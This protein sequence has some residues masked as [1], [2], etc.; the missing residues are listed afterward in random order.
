[1]ALKVI[2]LWKA[3]TATIMT[4]VRMALKAAIS[5]RGFR[6]PSNRRAQSRA[7]STVLLMKTEWLLSEMKR[8]VYYKGVQCAAALGY[9]WLV[10]MADQA[11]LA[12]AFTYQGLYYK[13]PSALMQLTILGLIVLC[14]A[15]TP[16]SLRQP[17]DTILYVLLPLVV[18]PVL[19]IAA[20]DALFA[21]VAHSMIIS[22][23]GAYLLLASCSKL[24]RPSMRRA[25]RPRPRQSWRRLWIL[26]VLLSVTCYGLMFGTFGIHFRLLS[27]SDVYGVRAVFAD[28]ASGVTGYLLEWQ[29]NVI[30]PLFVI[31]G[32]RSRRVAPL[33]A[34]VLGDFLIYSTTGFKSVLFSVLAVAAFLAAVRQKKTT[35]R[36]PATGVRLGIAFAALVALAYEI[37]TLSHGLTWT[38]LFVRRLSLVAGVNTGYYFQF[39][40]EVPKTH[41]AYGI[42]GKILGTSGAV[43]PTRQIATYVYHSSGAPNVNLWGDAY[44]NFG[45]F[46]VFFF[47]LILAAFMWYYDR[48]AHDIE[49]GAAIV[50]LV[51]PALSLANSALFTCFLTHG[52][53]LALLVIALW[54]RMSRRTEAAEPRLKDRPVV[55][56][57]RSAEI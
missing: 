26:A 42:V 24:P 52:L 40:S 41:L 45:Q 33:A 51:G 8:A 2:V 35:A 1:M 50:L 57:V 36:P 29:A 11:I 9:Y 32:V 54:P 27:F 5:P 15:V 20:S 34:G 48:L 7:V 39:F 43:S 14:T 16:I 37:D 22:V 10:C 38:S 6:Q 31:Y 55:S 4:H 18:I 30:N 49:R 21:S 46:G 13:S 44:A 17:S 28:Q 3:L 12:P 56:L 19:T 25:G 23:A 53:L 47:T